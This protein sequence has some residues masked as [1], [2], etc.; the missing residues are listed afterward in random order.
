[1]PTTPL[2]KK[3]RGLGVK[4]LFLPRGGDRWDE[5]CVMQP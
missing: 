2:R 3:I 4:R 1:M 5:S